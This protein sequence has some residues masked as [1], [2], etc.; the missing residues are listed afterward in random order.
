MEVPRLEVELVQ[1]LLAYTTA[2]AMQDPSCACN[3]HHSSWQHQI[4]TYQV[5]PGIEPALLWILVGFTTAEPQRE[6]LYYFFSLG[7]ILNVLQTEVRSSRA[8]E[9]AELHRWVVSTFKWERGW[10][11]PGLATKSAK[12]QLTKKIL[13]LPKTPVHLAQKRRSYRLEEW[14]GPH[15]GIQLCKDI[16]LYQLPCWL[17]GLSS[18]WGSWNVRL[19]SIVHLTMWLV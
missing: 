7:K 10:Q 12:R 17:P 15:G 11:C 4:L 6:L 2:T 16:H 5:R 9:A 19:C 14:I 3:R 18:R 8:G 13:V 1:Q